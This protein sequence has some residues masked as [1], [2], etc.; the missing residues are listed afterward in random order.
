[1][2]SSAEYGLQIVAVVTKLIGGDLQV[3]FLAPNQ[4]PS[5]IPS[6]WNEKGSNETQSEIAACKTKKTP[7]KLNHQMSGVLH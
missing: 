5:L 1:M 6:F 7:H 4:N 3:K 2:S